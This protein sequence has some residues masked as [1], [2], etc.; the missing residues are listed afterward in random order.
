MRTQ[1]E[2]KKCVDLELNVLMSIEDVT[3][4]VNSAV[5]SEMTS[6]QASDARRSVIAA[7]EN[8]SKD[9]TGLRSDVITLYQ[10]GVYHLYRFKRY[11]DVRL[12]FA[13]EQQSAF[14][15][16][17]PDNFEYPRF[18]L[19]IC[20]F[21]VYENGRPLKIDNYL[22]FNPRRP[23]DGELTFVSGHPGK[24]DRQL[25][26]DEMADMRDREL[27][28]ILTMFKRREVLLHSFGER[29][30]E[31]E[32]RVRDDFFGVQ[33][34]RKRYDGYL[35]GLLDP[36]IWQALEARE[37]KLRDAISGDPKL[38]S[39]TAAYD[40]IKNAQVEI[41]KNARV[42][43][44]FEM[45]RRKFGVYRQPRAF[46]STLFKYARLL[47]RA[48][49][50]RAKPNGERFEEFRDSAHESL[51]LE[52][53]STEPVYDDVELLTL[54][55]SF[56]DLAS[57][58]GASGPLVKM[59]LG[60]KSPVERASELI[61]G[62]Q[63]KDV[64]L[65]KELYAGGQAAIEAAHDPM[66]DIARAI[67]ATARQAKKVFET[68]EEIKQQAYAEI[69]KARFATEGTTSYPDATFTLRLSYGTVRGYEENG[70]QI[71][72]FTNVAGMY[73]RANEHE[74]KPPF[75]LPQRWMDKKDKLAL[76]TPFNFVSDADIIGGNSGSPV[77]NKAGE[78][79]GIIFD[80]NIQ[81][82]VLDCIFTDKQARAVSVDSAAILE[83]LR[84]VYDA[85]PLVD[86]LSSAK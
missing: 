73:D 78:F 79:V 59:V 52:L 71:S 16:G 1:A 11:D 35:A 46:Y 36:Q 50:E 76:T 27:P 33:N 12:V 31:N 9:K 39:T 56:T 69:A 23:I 40:R 18:D 62:T 84:N 10:G 82:L 51:E 37:Q 19:D 22:K 85:Q 67:D 5:K 68:Q 64:A 25:T 65:R 55:D 72:A 21:R 28:R 7:I 81:S 60:D 48:A 26:V 77:V 63:L 6:E 49:D 53:F 4:R 29:T 42:Y 54:T 45:E 14:Y 47:V 17:D 57:A 70:K 58:F 43:N 75:D 24:T 74:N 13:P 44:Y 38:T 61:K 34:N 2:E 83:A 15:G 80:G 20:I 86:E 8:E 30:F 66:I 41:A 3:A 32:R